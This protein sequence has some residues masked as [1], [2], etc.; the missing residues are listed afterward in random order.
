MPVYASSSCILRQQADAH[1]NTCINQPAVTLYGRAAPEQ[2]MMQ[3][4]MLT[5]PFGKY[6]HQ[7]YMSVQGTTVMLLLDSPLTCNNKLQAIG[8][9][10][11]VDLGGPSGTKNSYRSWALWVETWQ[12]LP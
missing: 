4:P 12:C 7:E 9:L 10:K 6:S 11:L 2:H 8:K 1:W 5:S 3:H